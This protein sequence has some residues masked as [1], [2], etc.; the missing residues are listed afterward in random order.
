MLK[1]EASSKKGEYIWQPKPLT[2]PVQWIAL[3]SCALEVTVVD[4]KSPKLVQ[5]GMG[6]PIQTGLSVPRYPGL[7]SGCITKTGY[8]I[9]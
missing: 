6:I 9:P 8:C 5:H 7:R 1:K 3:D 4:E 2:P